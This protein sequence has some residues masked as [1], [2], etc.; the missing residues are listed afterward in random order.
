[1]FFLFVCCYH[2]YYDHPFHC[3]L[4]TFVRQLLPN[5]SLFAFPET[6]VVVVMMMMT[7]T[8]TKQ[9]V[10]HYYRCTT[11]NDLAPKRHCKRTSV[12]Y[13]PQPCESIVGLQQ[14][15]QQQQP[16]HY[17]YEFDSS[18]LQTL[19]DR[20]FRTAHHQR[21]MQSLLID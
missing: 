17:R 20:I 19:I 2:Y 12:S 1:M 13:Y 7:T 16:T 21:G 8:T 10:A 5:D 9:N 14:Q 6:V 3:F 4:H 15:Q 18:T 11:S